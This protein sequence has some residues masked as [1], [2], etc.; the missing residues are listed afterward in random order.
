MRITKFTKIEGKKQILGA[1]VREIQ[2]HSG[3]YATSMGDI[4]SCRPL[5]GIGNFLP[6][7]KARIL[8][9]QK[10]SNGYETVVLDRKTLSVHRL[11]LE[12]FKGK[13]PKGKTAGHKNSIR[14]DTRLKN[15]Y[16]ATYKEQWRD[17]EAAG[18]YQR[19]ELNGSSK[20]NDNKVRNIRKIY[21]KRNKKYGAAA[22]AR[23]Y[24][25]DIS[26]LLSVVTRATWGHVV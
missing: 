24:Q 20:L 26:T 15:L 17:K 13:C 1:E 4:M 2:E 25:V 19:G 9:K 7:N 22:L 14:T 10:S 23:K 21:I 16:W 3:Y 18:T 6:L 11:I 5:N 12:T 8:K